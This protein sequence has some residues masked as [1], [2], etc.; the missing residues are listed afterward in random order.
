MGPLHTHTYTH[1]L[2]VWSRLP[3]FH[4]SY[5]GAGYPEAVQD[6][7][8]SSPLPYTH[9]HTHTDTHTHTHTH[10]CYLSGAGCHPSTTHT[11]VQDIPR[12]YTTASSPPP[13]MTHT[14]THTHT[15]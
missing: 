14:L 13:P 4:H 7:M 15:H 5:V 1:L 3:S 9:T 8:K 11:W 10:T 2:S 12:Q 6:S